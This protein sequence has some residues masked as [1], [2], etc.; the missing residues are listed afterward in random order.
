MSNKI[1]FMISDCHRMMKIMWK[2]NTKAYIWLKENTGE[3]VHFSE[4]KQ[5][6]ELLEKAHDLLVKRMERKGFDY[7]TGV[8]L[9]EPIDIPA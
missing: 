2:T 8:K 7:L 5:N 6:P 3:V 9:Q 4:I 1:G